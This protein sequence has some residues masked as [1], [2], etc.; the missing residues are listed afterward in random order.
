[1]FHL[2]EWKRWVVALTVFGWV[3]VGVQIA[4]AEKPLT[5]ESLEG[6]K[7]VDA[8]WV[9][10]NLG[11]VKLYDVRKKAEYVE[12][13]IPGAI[14]VPYKEKSAKKVGFDR[15]KDRLDLSKFPSDKTTPIVTQCNGPR[16]WKSYKAATWLVDAGY[17]N[18]HWF[19]GGLPEW[20]SKGY[21]TE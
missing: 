16:C 11:K 14:S 20:K 7:V 13:H 3:F 19:R 2:R 4:A 12:A 17:T 18:V 9:K 6:A 21:P 5:P 1:M 8:G 15:S 10:A